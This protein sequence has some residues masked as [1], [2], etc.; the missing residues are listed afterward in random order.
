MIYVNDGKLQADEVKVVGAGDVEAL[1]SDGWRILGIVGQS[2]PGPS[3]QSSVNW[4]HEGQNNS[5]NVNMPDQPV[6]TPQFIMGRDSENAKLHQRVLDAEADAQEAKKKADEINLEAG[7]LKKRLKSCEGDVANLQEQ[8]REK[9]KALARMDKE[10]AVVR[11]ELGEGKWREI[12]SALHVEKALEA[13]KQV[14]DD[15]NLYG[16]S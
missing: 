16:Q 1:V 2:S 6:F 10:T 13:E 9:T 5:A 7:E 3:V 15:V 8:N 4:Y 11:H 14:E 12:L